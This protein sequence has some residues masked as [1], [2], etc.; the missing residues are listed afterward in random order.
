MSYAHAQ[1]CTHMHAALR[2]MA[3]FPG[4]F[5]ELSPSEVVSY[6]SAEVPDLDKTVLENF[7]TH[8]ISGDVFI[9]LTEEYLRELVPLV[10]ERLRVKRAVVKAQ[11]HVTSVVCWLW[12]K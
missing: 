9:D 10:G 3:E 4:C 7:I 6:L 12:K 2:K 5:E 1:V 8:K 11:T